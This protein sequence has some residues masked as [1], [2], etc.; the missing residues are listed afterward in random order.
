MPKVSII[1]PVYNGERY[2][3]K[4]VSSILSQTLSDSEVILVDDGSTDKTPEILKEYAN[5][6]NRIRIITQINQ[7]QGAARNRGLEIAQ[8]EYITFIDADD[9]IDENY[10]EKMYKYASSANADLAISTSIRETG[11]RHRYHLKFDNYQVIENFD[12]ILEVLRMHW[13]PHSKLY[14]TEIAKS[15]KFEEG[16]YFEDGRYIVRFLNQTKKMV[17]VPKVAYHYV[18]N[19][20]STI[21][22]KPSIATILDRIESAID[23]INYSEE[24]NIKIPEYLIYKEIK[25]PLAIKHYKYKKIYHVF[26]IKIFNR[27]MPFE[28]NHNFLVFANKDDW[29]LLA[30]I[31]NIFFDS[32][33][34]VITDENSAKI[35]EQYADSIIIS[36]HIFDILKKLKHQ[37]IFCLIPLR[38]NFMKKFLLSFLKP[39]YVLKMPKE[40]F[41]S[42]Y[43][44]DK[45]ILKQITH[46]Q[47]KDYT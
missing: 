8:G 22:R 43:A 32:K 34:T 5:K 30:N 25:G 19:P 1:V 13:E 41:K 24:H 29:S 12:E 16:V 35:L 2:I 17:T 15:I 39:K 26:G 7:K 11:H 3:A 18:M 36:N 28:N 38:I 23:I 33:I 45:Y 21:K 44:K 9:W 31:K 42:S 37:K 47:I 14:K 27:N 6:D 40:V 46:R 10:L 20:N 4:C